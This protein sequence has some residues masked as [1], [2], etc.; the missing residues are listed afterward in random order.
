MVS[1]VENHK[2]E[3]S[4]ESMLKLCIARHGTCSKVHCTETQLWVSR[5]VIPRNHIK[6]M[7]KWPS[8]QRQPRQTPLHSRNLSP[9]RKESSSSRKNDHRHLIMGKP[10][11]SIFSA[12]VDIYR[13]S[14]HPPTPI[15]YSSQHTPSLGALKR[16]QWM[17]L[18]PWGHYR[19]KAAAMPSSTGSLV[20]AS[21]IFLSVGC[22][23]P[24]CLWHSLPVL[25]VVGVHVL[26]EQDAEFL[27][28]GLEFLKVLVVLATVLHLHL[29]TYGHG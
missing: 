13:C 24:R 9:I 23:G 1:E 20:V 4:I 19:Q 16:K 10:R 3:E 11:R 21:L 25:G 17:H 8:L 15:H 26:L 29:E 6:E 7:T 22:V 14:N 12:L 5:E 2:D 28:K 18:G 27:A